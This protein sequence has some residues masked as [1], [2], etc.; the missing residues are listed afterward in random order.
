M[1]VSYGTCLNCN[2]GTGNSFTYDTIPQS[3]DEV[4]IIPDPPPQFHFNIYFCQIC[5]SNSHY[6]YE[7]SQRYGDEHLNTISATK[8]NE[9]INSCVENLVPNPSESE[10]ENGCDMPAFFT[11]F[12]NILFDAEYEFDSVDDHSCSDEDILE[13]IF[14]NPLFKEGIIPMKID[15]HHHNAEFD[16]IES[17]LNHDSSIIFSSS[18]IDSLLDEFA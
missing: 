4:Q 8:S 18:N 17:M 7:C 2:S 5:E 1:C 9:F 3:F 6:G 13:K 15:Q 11:T 12:S 14:S 10:G 16:L